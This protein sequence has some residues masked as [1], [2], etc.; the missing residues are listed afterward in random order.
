MYDSRVAKFDAMVY[1]NKTAKVRLLGVLEADVSICSPY[2]KYTSTVPIKGPL[3]VSEN[4]S[5]A[6]MAVAIGR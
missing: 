3:T 1:G 2:S 4:N 6:K 5:S